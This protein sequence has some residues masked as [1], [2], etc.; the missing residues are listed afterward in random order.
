MF[1]EM[2][3]FDSDSDEETLYTAANGTAQ[4]VTTSYG[5]TMNYREGDGGV[6]IRSYKESEGAEDLFFLSGSSATLVVSF[7]PSIEEDGT[8]PR[9]RN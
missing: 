9:S 2:F 8:V 6:Y 5:A 4:L 3:V 7:V 1:L